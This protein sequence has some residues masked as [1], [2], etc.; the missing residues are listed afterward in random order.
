MGK[1]Q[2]KKSLVALSPLVYDSSSYQE[3]Y[4]RYGEEISKNIKKN[5][6]SSGYFDLIPS[7]AFIE[8]PA[9]TAVEPYPQN[10]RGFRWENWKLIRAEF[11]MFSRYVVQEGKIELRVYMYD[12]LLRRSLFQKRY[13]SSI[14]QRERLGDLVCNDI[15]EHLTKK[16][17]IFLTKIAAVRSTTG[18]KK[19]LFVMDWD[20]A[21]AKQVSFHR[22]IVLSP[23]W[24]PSG[25]QLAYTAFV[26]RRSLRGRRA[27][28]F[29][30][31]FLRKKRK[32]LS[33]HYGTNL[34]SDFFPSG[35]EMLV[36]L[37]SKRGG[38]NIFK[39]FIRRKKVHPLLIGP[40]GAINVEP[41]IHAKSGSIVFSSNRRGKVMLY[42]MNQYGENIKQLTF[43][44]S[45]NSSP[46]WSPDGR[47][48]VF[49][50]YSGG[51][52]DL[53]LLDTLNN[54]RIKRLTSF[55]RSNGR[56]ANHESPSFSPDGRQIVF[57]SD[58]TGY[59]QLY[60]IHID[61]SQLTRI[62]FDRFTY[63]SPRWSPLIRQVIQ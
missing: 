32:I 8:N 56:W 19:E 9:Q 16:P 45:Y 24:S 42:S 55:K 21:N 6:S 12:V 61:G 37:P 43:T 48:I 27:Y 25:L 52:F 36:T 57:T 49:S 46:D 35:K 39:Y 18:T 29:L 7:G 59:S 41:A 11:L 5:L 38:M 26:Y 28:I 54:N 62:T 3:D 2:V 50:G 34:G 17:G 31:D 1:A 22:S 53:F 13:T 51:R 14:A 10:P 40:R 33:S 23:S 60:I 63:K 20:G 30:Y 15:I 44:G 4:V 47:Y 58:R